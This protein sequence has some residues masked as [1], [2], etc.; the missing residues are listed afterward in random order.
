[1]NRSII[2]LGLET[3]LEQLV[4]SRD[5]STDNQE[6]IGYVQEELHRLKFRVKS[7]DFAR[8]LQY[9]L[10]LEAEERFGEFGF[11]T[12]TEEQQSCLLYTSPSPRDRTR[13]RMPSSA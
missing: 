4:D 8:W 13:S 5:N 2:I 10:D 1:M 6:K 9:T 7:K 11:N 12:L 3:L